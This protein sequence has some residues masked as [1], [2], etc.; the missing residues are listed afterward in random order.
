MYIFQYFLIYS[1][2]SL[3][4]SIQAAEYN[5]AGAVFENMAC[6]ECHQKTDS[7]VI[8]AWRNSIHAS[9]QPVTDCVACHGKS[10]QTA[11]SSSRK[12]NRCINCHGGKKA[13]VVH[14]YTTSKHGIIMQLEQSSYDWQQSLSMA[15]YRVPGCSYCHM[16]QGEHNVNRMT[17][18][19]LASSNEINIK[20]IQ[21]NIRQTCQDCHA[22]RYITHLL[23]NAEAMLEIAHKKVREADKIISMAADKFTI[24][25]LQPAREIRQTMQQHLINVY[26]GSAHQSPDYQW[27]HGQPALD[28]DL[29][30]IKSLVSDLYIEASQVKN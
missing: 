2:A 1:L 4:L 6:I 7:Q 21:I 8:S 28:G 25:Q 15:N 18:H 14:S 11:A 26:L 23:A 30:R 27:W 16:H 17:R 9:T 10:H 29:L 13:P 20:N 12:N 3:S 24:S 22:P 19:S 5:I